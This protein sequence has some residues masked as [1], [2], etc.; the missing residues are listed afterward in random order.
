MSYKTGIT[1]GI[2]SGKTSVCLI[3][4]MLGIPVYYSDTRA[5]QMMN[6]DT[7][8]KTAIADCF[9]S[10]I[11]CGGT[12]AR[13]K[14]A[15]IVFNN[16]TALEK[17]NSLVHPAVA[18]DFEQWQSQQTTPYTVEE[19][20]IIFESGIAERFDKIILVTAPEDIRIRRVCARD[21]A[22]PETVRER[23]KNQLPD[24]K[25]IPKAD[26]II[27][28]DTMQM[29]IPQVIEIHRRLLETLM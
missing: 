19:S 27:Y 21:N 4:E 25:K 5:K 8:L 3:F 9:G 1:G 12:L 13:R 29:V 11:Y 15:E 14:L 2:G 10:E 24:N 7:E 20:A 23:M 17:L 28:N 16:K 26:F 6:T 22:T 18:R